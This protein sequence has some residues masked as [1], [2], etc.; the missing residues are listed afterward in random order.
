[1][2]KRH[3]HVLVAAALTAA[4][5]HGGPPRFSAIALPQS[6]NTFGP[7]FVQGVTSTGA[8]LGSGNRIWRSG[9]V[10]QIATGSAFTGIAI[11]ESG[12]VVGGTATPRHAAF[13]SEGELSPLESGAE[14]SFAAGVSND[15]SIIAGSVGRSPSVWND[16]QR[17]VTALDTPYT[18]G[19]FQGVGNDGTAVGRALYPATDIPELNQSHGII[20]HDG[21]ISYIESVPGATSIEQRW[22]E[23]TATN[24]SGHS[25]GAASDLSLAV[26]ALGTAFEVVDGQIDT[27]S[28]IQDTSHTAARDINDNGWI[29]GTSYN[30]TTDTRFATLWLG[31]VAYN[32]ND[33]LSTTLGD[34]QVSSAHAVSNSG[35]IVVTVQGAGATGFLG[36]VSYLLTPIP[37]PS[38]TMCI[39]LAIGACSRRRR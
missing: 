35:H 13:W 7:S 36:G 37:A 17:L 11:S 20:Q 38:S 2:L 30:Q 21:H 26:N 10:E 32:L 12:V 25:V 19:V 28:K 1:M 6:A 16:G 5:A 31:G 23:V 8:V 27:L 24:S 18:E 3:A 15:G 9:S 4:G 29:V 39:A 33:L 14:R 34:L 22:I